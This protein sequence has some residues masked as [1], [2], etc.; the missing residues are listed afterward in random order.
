MAT[1]IPRHWRDSTRAIH[2]GESKHG[3][4]GPVVTPIVRSSTFTFS[5]SGGNEAL[6]RG[7]K[8]GVHLHALR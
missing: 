6:G 2:A 5:S 8:Q 4:G 7:Q 1:E 3:V